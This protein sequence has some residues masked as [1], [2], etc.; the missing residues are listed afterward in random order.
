MDMRTFTSACVSLIVAVTLAACTG[1]PSTPTPYAPS[2]TGP[3]PTNQPLAVTDLD[4]FVNGLELAGHEVR[5][6][7][8]QAGVGENDI[9]G[10]R[11]H[12]VSFDGARVMA[13]E[14]QT[15]RAAQ[16]LQQS[17]NKDGDMIGSW[18]ID[19]GG[20][21]LYRRGTLIVVYLGQRSGAIR[22]LESLLGTQFAPV[23]SA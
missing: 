18:I 17:V 20:Q 15:E 21:H 10:V 1:N 13:F 19:W 5:V 4:S 3:S 2:V 14:Y 7:R 11:G 12:N 8:H 16:R 9:F 23:L 6:E 22:T